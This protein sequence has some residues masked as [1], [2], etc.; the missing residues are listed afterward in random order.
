[1]PMF[2]GAVLLTTAALVAYFDCGRRT[3]LVAAASAAALAWSTRYAGAALVV[4]AAIACL[5]RRSAPRRTRMEDALIVMALSAWPLLIWIARN[6]LVSSPLERTAM[7]GFYP[8]PAQW[9]LD[10][11]ATIRRWFAAD[12]APWGLRVA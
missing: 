7:L 3:F 2:V 8:P 10:A 5:T 1:E 6:R 12:D 4:A 11:L 9:Y